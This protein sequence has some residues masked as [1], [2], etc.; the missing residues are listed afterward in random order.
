MRYDRWKGVNKMPALSAKSVL[1][2]AMDIEENGKAF[3]ETV[4]E[5]VQDREA[6]VIFQDL[7]YQEERHYRT[8]RNML[9]KVPEADVATDSA[10]YQRYLETALDKALFEGPEKGLALAKEARNEEEALEAAIA[11]EKDTLL[12]FYDLLEMVPRSQQEAISAVIEQEKSHV[13]QLAKVLAD[14]PWV[15]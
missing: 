7:A 2:W 1:R 6:K 10:E 15:S 8:F 3:Y 11:F 13:R 4:A 5:R 12:F 14:R 9:D